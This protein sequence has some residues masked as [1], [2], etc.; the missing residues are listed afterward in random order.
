MLTIVI[1][2]PGAEK[3][4]FVNQKGELKE[5][6]PAPEGRPAGRCARIAMDRMAQALKDDPYYFD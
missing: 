5:T 2:L 6:S 4:I 1:E 3:L